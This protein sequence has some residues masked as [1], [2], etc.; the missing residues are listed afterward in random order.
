ML[1]QPIKSNQNNSVARTLKILLVD[2]QKS[3]QLKLQEI[4]SPQ[5]D[6]Q[7]VGTAD[8]GEI[9]ITQIESLQ[10]DVVLLDI[11]M[12]KINLRGLYLQ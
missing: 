4:L 7:V 5:V 2:D 6:L 11:E 10:P 12:P 1:T 3:I 9:A 8:N